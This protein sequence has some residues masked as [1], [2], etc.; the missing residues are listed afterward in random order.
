MNILENDHFED[1]GGADRIKNK[2]DLGKT[3][4]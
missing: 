1:K 4:C 2:L 3:I